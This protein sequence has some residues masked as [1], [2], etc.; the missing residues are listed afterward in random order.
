M[1]SNPLLKFFRY[2]FYV[3]LI[4]GLLCILIPIEP[5]TFQALSFDVVIRRLSVLII[6]A[7]FLERALEVY[8]L[9]Y[10]SQKKER[11]TAEVEQR[12]LELNVLLLS[13]AED[14]SKSEA[15]QESKECLFK[16]EEKLQVHQ[17][18]TR[19][20][21]LQV[22]IVFALLLSA[23]GLRSL[24]GIVQYPS[25]ETISEIFRLYLFRVLDLSLTAG[26]IA[27]GSEGIHNI[28]KKIYSFFPDASQ[29]VI[30]SLQAIRKELT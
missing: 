8:K 6:V 9:S 2:S 12:Q 7:L 24:E 10:F 18:Y 26:L 11:L 28:I 4:C 20:R 29:Q 14:S 15:I 17:D 3:I 23:V 27:G 21:I 1:E 5:L 16:A 13:R 25:S 22:A 30:D 19:Q